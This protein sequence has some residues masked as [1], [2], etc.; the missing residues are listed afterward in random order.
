MEK[1]QGGVS[2]EVLERLQSIIRTLQNEKDSLE[3]RLAG[4]FGK[5]VFDCDKF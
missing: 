2:Q 5:D 1:V 3:K 4:T